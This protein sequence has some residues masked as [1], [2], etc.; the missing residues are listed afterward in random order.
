MSREGSYQCRSG[1][2]FGSEVFRAWWKTAEKPSVVKVWHELD[3]EG[4]CRWCDT[5]RQ[6]SQERL[7]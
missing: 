3:E 1:Q 4:R 6:S 2:E 7:G 5:K